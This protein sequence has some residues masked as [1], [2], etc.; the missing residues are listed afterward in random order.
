M[1]AMFR[2]G[3]ASVILFASLI[4]VFSVQLIFLAD[5]GTAFVLSEILTQMSLQRWF[6][7][8]GPDAIC[9]RQLPA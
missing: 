2:I 1:Y 9:A 3:N 8:N 6:G 7:A 5:A 4:R